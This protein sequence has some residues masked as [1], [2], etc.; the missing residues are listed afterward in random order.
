MFSNFHLR[1][2]WVISYLKHSQLLSGLFPKRLGRKLK[3]NQADSDKTLTYSTLQTI[4]KAYSNSTSGYFEQQ[5][6][7]SCEANIFIIISCVF[8]LGQIHQQISNFADH[9]LKNKFKRT[10]LGN[11]RFSEQP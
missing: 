5:E 2:N 7:F 10:K 4:L 8:G 6:T 1:E 3:L 11:S 9:F